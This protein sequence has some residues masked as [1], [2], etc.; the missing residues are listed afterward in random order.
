MAKSLVL[1]VLCLLLGLG[2]VRT[3][4]AQHRSIA[5]EWNE[6]LLDAIRND[7]ARPTVHA[8][9][10][11]HA[12]II[13]YDSWAFFQQGRPTYLLGRDLHGFQSKMPSSPQRDPGDAEIREVLSVAMYRLL[14]YRF[15]S[16]PA[17]PSLIREMR[18]KMEE[19][20]YSGYFSDPPNGL[21]I[22]G[23]EISGYVI[24]Y[25]LQDGSNERMNYSN[26]FYQ[27]V[28]EA[29]DP[30]LPGNPT[31]TDPDRWQSLDLGMFI[32][33]S[34]NPIDGAIDFLSPEWGYVSPFALTE[35]DQ[36]TGFRE[37]EM[38]IYHDPGP[39]PLFSDED[40]TLYKWGFELVAIWGSHLDPADEVMWDIS[41][42]RIGNIPGLPE[43]F[44]E[45][46]EFYNLQDGGDPSL[47]WDQNPATGLPYEP[48]IVPRADYVRVLAEFWA[49][50]PDSETPPGH[51]FTI[52][53]YVNDH[54]LLEKRFKGEGEILEELEWDVKAYFVLGGAMHDAAISAWSIK[55]WHDYIRPIS[56]I[57]YLADQ[58]QS[59][60]PEGASYDPNGISLHDGLIELVASGD[61]LAGE[62]DEHVGKIK[63]YS[64]RGPDYIDDPDTD[65]AGV[66]W[67]LAEHWWPYQRP[68]FVTPPFAGYVSGHSTFSRAAAEVLTLLTG[69]EFFPGGLGE[70][71]AKKNEFLVFEEG[72]SQDIVLQWATYRDASDQTSLSR[73]WGG[74]H[75]P[76]DDI[77]GRLIG[78]EVGIDAFNFA[79]RVFENDFVLAQNSLDTK[80][81]VF[82]N[83]A[84][85]GN[86]ISIETGFG[87]TEMDVKLI[88]L[89]GRALYHEQ[90]L[91]DQSEQILV[92]LPEIWSGLFLLLIE[93]DGQQSTRKI[94]IGK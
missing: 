39:P 35:E 57:R 75:P 29:L 78:I 89:Q 34:G 32:D 16:S 11:F 84:T 81:K 77:P 41:P 62:N 91:P 56:A 12:S 49:D 48:Q 7:F 47:G 64:W 74:I 79:E 2:F 15:R 17:Y 70:F 18:N 22:L 14:E 1:K 86:T 90:I 54:P 63:L 6:I 73:I 93:I 85:S 50:G 76:M 37:R 3:P 94:R 59:T 27:T 10:L 21:A 88:D 92:N 40:N 31:L 55:G 8:R 43:T 67:I 20:G 68:T 66:D 60:F 24:E 9:N 52:L 80:L 72:P 30:E 23:E 44:T 13:M 33:Q 69:D 5:R 25:G 4:Q 19:W 83:P 58:G 61:P 28:N 42:G 26:Q 71:E 45:M 46:L 87:F 38:V 36:T 51:W 65:I 82:P 53:N